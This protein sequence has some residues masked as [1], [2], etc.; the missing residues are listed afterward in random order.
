MNVTGFG[1]GTANQNKQIVNTKLG[2]TTLTTRVM[3]A[4]RGACGD[5]MRAQPPQDRAEAVAPAPAPAT[6]PPD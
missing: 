4:A 1:F 3:R 6:S 2:I 5:G